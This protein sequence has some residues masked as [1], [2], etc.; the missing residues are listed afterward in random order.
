[1]TGRKGKQR[2]RPSCDCCECF[3]KLREKKCLEEIFGQ[4]NRKE[5]LVWIPAQWDVRDFPFLFCQRFME[6]L[7][8]GGALK[9]IQSQP[10]PRAGTAPAIPGCSKLALDTSGDGASTNSL[11]MPFQCFTTLIIKNFFLGISWNELS[12]GGSLLRWE[13]WRDLG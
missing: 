7:G 12:C 4:T 6:W 5:R 3:H 2:E 13:E 1:M 9:I 8:L 10:I 11:E